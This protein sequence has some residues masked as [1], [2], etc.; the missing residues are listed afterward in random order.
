MPPSGGCRGGGPRCHRLEVAEVKD[1]DSLVDTFREVVWLGWWWD[2]RE[3]LFDGSV[4]LMYKWDLMI[5]L[6]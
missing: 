5:S 4:H 6:S 3:G 2:A 1:L